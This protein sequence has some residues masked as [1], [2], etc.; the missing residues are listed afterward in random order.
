M[1]CKCTLHVTV[2]QS[3]SHVPVCKPRDCSRPGSSV[4]GI[5]QARILAIVWSLSHV[6]SLWLHGLQHARLPCPLPSPG[7]YSKTPVHLVDDAIQPSHPLSSP[8][9][10]AFPA[11][12]SFP[13]SQFF[14]SGGQSI[15]ASASTSVL[16]MNIQGWFPL[17]LIGL[18]S[19]QFKGLS[20]T[21]VWKYQFF[22]VQPSLSLTSIHSYCKKLSGLLLSFKNK[23][24]F[25]T[26]QNMGEPWGYLEVK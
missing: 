17:G 13:V 26:H 2:V 12:G 21:A 18:I 19:L 22:G 24:N 4:H 14:P 5:L 11:S 16:P 23:G 3:L 6:N 10:P 25:D 7:A 15:G 20:N 9:P 8:S 1:F